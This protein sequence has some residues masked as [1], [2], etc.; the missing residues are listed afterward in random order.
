[1]VEHHRTLLARFEPL[2][3]L[4]RI[5]VSAKEGR[6][7]AARLNRFIALEAHLPVYGQ[8]RIGTGG[9]TACRAG[10]RSLGGHRGLKPG[11]IQNEAPFPRNIRR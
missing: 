11:L 4:K 6:H 10:P 1:M 3:D 2:H 7:R 9:E 5:T 8:L